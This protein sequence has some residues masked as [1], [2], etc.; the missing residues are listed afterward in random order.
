MELSRTQTHI[1]EP[2]LLADALQK[3]RDLRKRKQRDSNA[4][5]AAREVVKRPRVKKPKH[6]KEP[7]YE[8]PK[9]K[10]K[11]KKK[12]RKYDKEAD[13]ERKRKKRKEAAE[14]AAAL[15]ARKKARFSKKK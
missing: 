9:P 14:A 3:S 1:A 7:V 10:V 12:K 13:K 15:L 2:Q 8:L 4:W 11:P 5:L 6:Y